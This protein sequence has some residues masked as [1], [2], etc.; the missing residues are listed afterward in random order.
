MWSRCEHG[1]ALTQDRSEEN[2]QCFGHTVTDV[3][4]IGGRIP[5]LASLV[6]SDG[7]AQLGKTV[8][9]EYPL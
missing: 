8:E 7:M 9:G 2:L 3:G 6:V 1:I 4:V 5:T